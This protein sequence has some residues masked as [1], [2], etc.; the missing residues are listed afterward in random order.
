MHWPNPTQP[1]GWLGEPLARAFAILGARTAGREAFIA[2]ESLSLSLSSPIVDVDVV[3]DVVPGR[4]LLQLRAKE[5][6]PR[7]R[8][9]TA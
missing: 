3:V 5:R 6:C 1:P 4:K 2:K 7:A 8:Q 9:S